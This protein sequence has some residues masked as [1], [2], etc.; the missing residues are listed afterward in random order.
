[1]DLELYMIDRNG[2]WYNKAKDAFIIHN[3]GLLPTALTL[4]EWAKVKCGKYYTQIRVE[5]IL[6]P[7]HVYYSKDPKV[8]E[9]QINPDVQF[10]FKGFRK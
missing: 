10:V 1:M 4:N 5:D 8:I 6:T 3:K 7:D 9:E 2:K